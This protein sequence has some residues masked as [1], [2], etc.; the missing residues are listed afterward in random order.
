MSKNSA[1]Y[2]GVYTPE[3]PEKYIGSKPIHYRSSW[4]SNVAYFLDHNQNVVRWGYEIIEIPYVSF[5]GRV[6]KYIMDFYAEIVTTN[7][8]IQKFL[9]EVKPEGNLNSV[10]AQKPPVRPKKRTPK[11]I[12]NF[13]YESKTYL[14]NRAKWQ[15]AKAFCHSNG[16]KFVVWTEKNGFNFT[17]S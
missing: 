11:S 17:A 15:S 10:L 2:H 6:H 12:R 5:D 8:S 4:E 16:L 7:Q 13:I 3:F 9:I 14:Q 1:T